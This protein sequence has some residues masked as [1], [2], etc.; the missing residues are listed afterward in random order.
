[1][2]AF[3]RTLGAVLSGILIARGLK[4]VTHSK[5]PRLV[6]GELSAGAA[7]ERAEVAYWSAENA[8]ADGQCSLAGRLAYH[9]RRSIRIGPTRTNARGS[10]RAR[11]ALLDPKNKTLQSFLDSF[12]VET[13]TLQ[14]AFRISPGIQ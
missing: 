4:I 13:D 6:G 8:A 7:S 9:A 5:G 11:S 3:L 14:V 10:A 1:M 12:E 2:E